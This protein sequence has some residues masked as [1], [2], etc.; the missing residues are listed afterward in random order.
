VANS[1]IE[2]FLKQLHWRIFDS[3]AEWHPY[4]LSDDPLVRSNGLKNASG[5]LAIPVSPRR[6][7]VG[8]YRGGFLDEIAQQKDLVEQVNRWVVE[9]ARHFVA[10]SDLSQT[11][12][13]KNRFGLKPKPGL[14][15]SIAI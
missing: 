4:L 9:G 15:R 13:I 3:P 6:L 2:K 12:F 5:H 7:V 14:A 10:A 8:A 1:N 11:R